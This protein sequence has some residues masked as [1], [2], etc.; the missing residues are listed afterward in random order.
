[1]SPLSPWLGLW[2]TSIAAGRGALDLAERML[3]AEE[4]EHARSPDRIREWAS[5]NRVLLELPTMRLR[6]FEAE[7]PGPSAIVVAPY[8]LHSAMT[9]DFATGHSVVETLLA[10]GIGRVLVTDWRS[11][12]P[13]QGCMGVDACL[14]DLNVAVDELGPPAAMAGLCQGGWLAAVYAARFPAKVS[15]LAI[16]GAPLDLDA[17]PSALR[18]LVRNTPSE[19]IREMIT[20]GNGVMLGQI[21]RSTWSIPDPGPQEIANTLQL[22]RVPSAL[23][24][25]FLSWNDDIVDLPGAFYVETAE[26]IFRDN[27]LACGAYPALGR[28]VGLTDIACPVHLLAGR[29]DEIVAPAQLLAFAD[30]HRSPDQ[31]SARLV[32][33]SHLSLFMGRITLRQEWTRIAAFLSG[34]GKGRPPKPVRRGSPHHA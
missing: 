7:V 4:A 32:D 3:G 1:M 27:L 34:I 18:E 23:A 33:G 14:A 24:A 19:T 9:A 6:T 2:A 5:P 20:L 29:G 13:A 21:T 31:A 16:V 25:Q 22:R 8:A 26:R 11:A 30:V 12:T 17:A 10:G 28:E 15:R